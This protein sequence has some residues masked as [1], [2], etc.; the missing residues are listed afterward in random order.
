MSTIVGAT[1]IE[2]TITEAQG[3]WLVLLDGTTPFN[4]YNQDRMFDGKKKYYK[5]GSP[6]QHQ[7]EHF[8]RKLNRAFNTDRFKVVK[9]M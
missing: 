1:S 3:W 6:H 7:A 8:A 9:V 5:N 2:I 4:A